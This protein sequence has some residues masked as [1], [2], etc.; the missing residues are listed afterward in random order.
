MLFET[1]A[2][3]LKWM[4]GNNEKMAVLMNKLTNVLNGIIQASKFDLM[5]YA[6]QLYSLF[7]ASSTE[8]C[9]LFEALM[10]SMVANLNNWN[11]D[12]KYLMPSQGQFIVAM[13]CK[14]P[15]YC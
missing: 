13:L 6:F 15:Q 3:T 14:Y 12:M 10:Q 9:S 8:N 1:T 2:L 11:P 7:V 4:R 5:G